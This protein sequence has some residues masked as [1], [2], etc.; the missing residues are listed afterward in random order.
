MNKMDYDKDL[1]DIEIM[2]D[3]FKVSFNTVRHMCNIGELPAFKIGKK[4]W[5]LKTDLDTYIKKQAKNALK[6]RSGKN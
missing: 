3:V 6:K 1:M 5:M 4:W 2:A